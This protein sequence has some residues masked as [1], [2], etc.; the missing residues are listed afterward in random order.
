[1][2]SERYKNELL[3]QLTIELFERFIH[4]LFQSLAFTKLGGLRTIQ[5]SRLECVRPMI[6]M[7]L[8]T[9]P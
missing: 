6:L 5:V 8:F 9:V 3:H 1:M 7:L 4:F 2:C